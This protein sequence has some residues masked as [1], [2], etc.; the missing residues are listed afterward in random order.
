MLSRRRLTFGR[1]HAAASTL[2][3][4]VAG[5]AAEGANERDIKAVEEGA[6]ALLLAVGAVNAE[7]NAAVTR[8]LAA[9]AHARQAHTDDRQFTDS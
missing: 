5:L 9:V 1:Y 3:L 7:A 4:R 8:A 6:L 2:D